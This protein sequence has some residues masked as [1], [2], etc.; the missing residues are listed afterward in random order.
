M[1]KNNFGT[2]STPD[3]QI[4]QR[5]VN[6]HFDKSSKYW[7][8]LYFHQNV[9]GVIHQERRQIALEYFDSLSLQEESNILE[10]GCGAGHTTVD[11]AKRGYIIEAIDSVPGMIELTQKHAQEAGLGSRI[12]A[13]IGDTHALCF[14]ENSFDCIIAMGVIPWVYDPWKVF[15]E[16]V[17]V[18]KP[19]GFVI[20]NT[21]NRYRLHH[22]SDPI[23]LPFMKPIKEKLKQVLETLGLR[24]NSSAAKPHMYSIKEFERMI[25]EN[26]LTIMKYHNYGF[27]PFTLFNR[28]IFGDGIGIKLHKHLQKLSDNG[29]PVLRRT[30]S[31]YIVLI[32][33]GY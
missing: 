19:Q 17:R 27:G 10:I 28:N 18:L 8:D 16:I 1:L 21:T 7:S 31:Q 33:K 12:S 32:Q 15:R 2:N 6:I 20:I 26:K 22:W 23:L 29:C 11:L 13:S 3:N 5:Q 25:S 24:K 30:G 4:E 9:F 14:P